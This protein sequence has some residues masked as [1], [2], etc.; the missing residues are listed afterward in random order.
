MSNLFISGIL[1]EKK[2]EKLETLMT[3]FTPNHR[4]LFGV[5]KSDD[6]Y[7]GLQAKMEVEF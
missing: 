1:I 6:L 3:V 2:R 5:V 4:K 7:F